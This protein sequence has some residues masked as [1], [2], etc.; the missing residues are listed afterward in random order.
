[1]SENVDDQESLIDEPILVVRAL[2][3]AL[4]ENLYVD[5]V[6]R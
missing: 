6:S 1:M 4:F 3:C 2:V 5:S